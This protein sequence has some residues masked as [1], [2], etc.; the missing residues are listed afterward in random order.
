MKFVC[1][2]HRHYEQ[3]NT[4]IHTSPATHQLTL[5]EYSSNTNEH[6]QSFYQSKKNKNKKCNSSRSA[7]TDCAR[8]NRQIE[9]VASESNYFL[10]SHTVALFP[11]DL[12]L[13][14]C[15]LR[16]LAH[17]HKMLSHPQKNS[18]YIYWRKKNHLMQRCDRNMKT[19]LFPSTEKHQWIQHWSNC[20][21]KIHWGSPADTKRNDWSYIQEKTK[22]LI[23]LFKTKCVILFLLFHSDPLQR[24]N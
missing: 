13:P 8:L 6:W 12:H 16:H 22:I 23:T 15:Q 17:W 2:T 5:S 18:Y 11:F 4:I 21:D 10:E 9:C 20:F 3:P 1:I 24:H 14:V 19:T 7:F